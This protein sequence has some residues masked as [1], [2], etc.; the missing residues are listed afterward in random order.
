MVI[1]SSLSLTFP[2][3]T[4]DLD[5]TPVW[6]SAAAL[7]RIPRGR[8]VSLRLRLFFFF[9]QSVSGHKNEEVIGG[10]SALWEGSPQNELRYYN[11]FTT[12]SPLVP[13]ASSKLQRSC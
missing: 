7:L 8:Y 12:H 11:N 2:I 1:Y 3:H 13:E 4:L 5:S 6:P 9:E 10:A